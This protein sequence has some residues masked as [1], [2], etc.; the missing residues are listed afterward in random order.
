MFILFFIAWII[1]NGNLTVE[2]AG[3]GVLFSFLLTL[4]CVKVLDYKIHKE[5]VMLKKIGL[6][7]ELFGVLIFEIAKSMNN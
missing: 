1:F 5:W 2:I 7:I 6:F 3:F 4:F